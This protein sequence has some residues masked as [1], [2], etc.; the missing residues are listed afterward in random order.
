MAI[1]KILNIKE[2]KGRNPASH[3]ENALQYIQSPDKTEE[4][5]LVGSIN[6]LPDTAFEQM[7]ETKNI[8]HKTGNRQGYHVILSF[9]PEEKVTAEQAMY[10]LE[11]FAKD[12]L[13]DDYEAVFAVHTDREHMHGHLIWN[14]VSV[15][16]G[17]KYN[18]P[19]G[20]WKNHLQPVTNKYCEMLGLEIMPAEYAKNPVNMSKEKWEYEQSFKDYILNDAKL[21]LSYA[22]SLEHFIFLMKRMGYEFKGKDYLSV[23]MPGMKLYHRLDKLD[24]IFSKEEMS[25]IL[26]YGYGHYYRKYQ[27]KGILYVKR[28]N[29]TPMQKKYYAKMYRLGLIEKKCYQYRSA[30]MAKEIKRMQFLQEQYLFICKNE[31]SSIADLIRLKIEANQTL[32]DAGNRQKEIYKERTIRKRKC[33][34]VE[35][36]KEYQIW[37]LE[38]A[39][40]LDG[41]KAEKKQAKS[42]I[43]MIN[44]CM[45]ENLYTAFGYV[46]EMEELNYG[47]EDVLPVM[48]DYR[49]RDIAEEFEIVESM[50]R[51]AADMAETGQDEADISKDSCAVGVVSAD[52][53]T[54]NMIEKLTTEQSL[55]ED[56]G[57]ELMQSFHNEHNDDELGYIEA[58]SSFELPADTDKRGYNVESYEVFEDTPDVSEKMAEDVAENGRAG[59]DV[60]I[61][62]DDIIESAELTVE[63]QA[64][65][66]AT[67]I[68]KYYKSYD[69]LSVENKA[70]LFNFRIDD[71]SY[72]L[73][74]HAGVLK[75]LGIHMYGSD[76]FEDYQSIYGETM[77][78]VE[79]QDSKYEYGYDGKKWERDRGR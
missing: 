42:D 26:K 38:S 2:S 9:S 76:R 32:E 74:L 21:C 34:T 28:A 54:D 37:N 68:Q 23:K 39:N 62:D 18:S 25:V 24:D 44:A 47:A 60:G 59:I 15:T 5:V 55:Y 79:K 11:H 31:V 70:R 65:Q 14:S 6:C 64:E 45:S 4:C 36:F 52:A 78:N 66:I 20:N 49:K 35:V 58:G 27:T 48:Y 43:R 12:V 50:D 46:D 1:T 51:V 57:G 3:L 17:K 40:E 56:F 7:V 67:A 13:G 61:T 53:S 41:L 19:K 73:E 8:F 10:V 16:T 71:N 75:K 72:N 77:K 33:K 29:L 22:G 30:E 63:G 69:Y